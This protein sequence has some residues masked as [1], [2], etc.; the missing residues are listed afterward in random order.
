MELF[1]Q[2]CLSGIQTSKYLSRICLMLLM[3][4]V[5]DPQSKIRGSIVTRKVGDFESRIVC[6]VNNV[7]I[8]HICIHRTM[9]TSC[10]CHVFN[11]FGAKRNLENRGVFLY[12]CLY[13]NYELA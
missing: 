5:R 7:F 4:Y 12:I 11:L 9:T 10:L 13:G 3:A 6:G 2:D 1:E 8:L